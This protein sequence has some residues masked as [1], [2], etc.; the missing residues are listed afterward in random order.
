MSDRQRG[1]GDKGV[2]IVITALALVPLMIF[3]AFGVDLAS[4]YS[5]I[6]FVQKSADAAALAGTVWMPDLTKSTTVACASLR[7]NGMTG[8]PSCGT[9]PF[10]VTVARGSTSTSLRVTVTDPSAA[11]YFS[12][13]MGSGDQ[14]LSRA[15]E[16]EY[17]LPI[18]LGSPLNFF[19]GDHTR[20]AQAPVTTYAVTWPLDYTARAPINGA[21]N[22][23]TSSAQG[24]GRWSGSPPT[25]NPT[26]FSGSTQCQWTVTGSPAAGTTPVPP[27]DYSTRAATNPT[28]WAYR[29][30]VSPG[31]IF[32]R[33]QGSGWS[34]NTSGGTVCSWG[35]YATN[36]STIPSFA[37]TVTPAN[38]ACRVGYETS[39]PGGG[40]WPAS[41]GFL[42]ATPARAIGD[43]HTPDGNQLCR[44]NADISS[45]TTTAPNPISPTRSPGFWAQIEGP[46]TIATNGDIFSTRV[47]HHRELRVG[48]E[49][50]VQG[51]HR[52][53]PGLLVRG[54][55]AR[56]P[57][58]APST[59]TSSTPPTTPTAASTVLAGDRSFSS[60][61]DLPHRVPGV[62][63]RPTRSTSPAAPP[64]S[65]RPPATRPTAAATGRVNG[66][67]NT[68]FTGTWRRLCTITGPVPGSTYLVNVQTP[69]TAGNG[70]NGYALEAVTGGSHANANQPALYAYANMGMYNNNACSPTPCTPPPATFY[71]AEVGPQYAGQTLVVDLWDPG[72]VLNGNASMYP[73]KPSP[74]VPRPVAD[75]PAAACSY[76]S[77]PAPNPVQSGGDPTGA[78]YASPAALRRQQPVR[79]HHRHGRR[80]ALQRHLAHHPHRP[81]L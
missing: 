24:L 43:A 38:R 11:R 81:P 13:V 55:D 2:A 10:E 33:W 18:P 61:S 69:G 34:T 64:C 67:A 62:P 79:D 44:W 48:A 71:L 49:P 52:P 37:N 7:E 36:A 80:P 42:P 27:P 35:N 31:T 41:G 63:S 66:A 73:K 65:P 29:D 25:Y 51:P 19:G 20:T 72:D 58:W 6:S 50:R 1:R 32:G 70:V 40:F 57:R 60:G 3:A 4:W 78:T 47:L 30:G 8:G 23:G 39:G 15:A 14:R 16:A 45:T 53:R 54:E 76:T 12:Q 5:R 68:A 46:A 17:N 28:C 75:V 74:T 77:S 21:C 59:S 22:V 56:P 9:G 26:G